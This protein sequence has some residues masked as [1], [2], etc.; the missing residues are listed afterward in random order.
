MTKGLLS[1]MLSNKT[2]SAYRILTNVELS[3]INVPNYIKEAI[4]WIKE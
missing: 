2:E 1:F 4:E 3:L